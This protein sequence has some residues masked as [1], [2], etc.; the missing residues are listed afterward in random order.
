MENSNE[1]IELLKAM[2]EQ[3]HN[4]LSL[5]VYTVIGIFTIIMAATGLW[6]YYI[7]RR[8]VNKRIEKKSEEMK[9]E[10]I[11]K[12]NEINEKYEKIDDKLYSLKIDVYRLF[13]LSTAMFMDYDLTLSWTTEGLN[14]ALEK[15]DNSDIR[16]F[17]D[18]AIKLL[19]LE[20]FND[21]SEDAFDPARLKK[22]LDEVP[23]FFEK[24]VKEIRAKVNK[25]KKK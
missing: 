8:E 15:A 18:S 24:E 21:Y 17:L 22:C 25:L 11:K 7:S 5:M 1:I 4:S 12:I 19:R 9:E 14:L 6:N 20:V 23:D 2:L 13:S 16:F 10:L 3:Q